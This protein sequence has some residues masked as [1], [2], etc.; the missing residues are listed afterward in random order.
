[1]NHVKAE[2]FRKIGTWILIFILW[3]VIAWLLYPLINL[4]TV[5]MENAKEYLYRS[6]FGIILMLIFF[7][8]T[9][10][11]LLFPQVT[12]RKIPLMN[13]IFLTLYA[14]VLAGGII[15]MVLRMMKNV[16]LREESSVLIGSD[17]IVQR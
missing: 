12:Y 16:C 13:T 5:Q 11:D 15:F 4:D 17:S 3:I 10:F 9:V 8:K 14:F 6:A 7:G 1:M 2:G